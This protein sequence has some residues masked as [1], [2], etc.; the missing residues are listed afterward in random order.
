MT[1]RFKRFYCTCSIFSCILSSWY[2]LWVQNT[3]S[4]LLLLVVV[5]VAAQIH[6]RKMLRLLI[7]CQSASMPTTSTFYELLYYVVISLI[8]STSG[9]LFAIVR[10]PN[11][12][13]VQCGTS[14]PVESH[15]SLSRGQ[16]SVACRRVSGCNW[17]NFMTEDV[18]DG[19]DVRGRCQLFDHPPQVGVQQHC[20]LYKVSLSLD[21]L[22][23]IEAQAV[24]PLSQLSL[25]FVASFRTSPCMRLLSKCILFYFD[26]PV[27]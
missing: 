12:G 13:L 16:C 2:V 26:P 5:V 9:S 22:V 19:P 21:Y 8:S 6:W 27:T 17:F 10:C 18:I 24:L 1:H 15:C 14:Q 20:S 23:C 7:A 25:L 4:S 3:R 11:S